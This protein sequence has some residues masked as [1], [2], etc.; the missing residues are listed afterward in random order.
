ML[1]VVFGAV[2]CIYGKMTAGEY[3]AFISYNSLLVWPVRELGRML[4]DMSK[5]GVS[6]ARINYIMSSENEQDKDGAVTPPMN[7]DNT[8]ELR[9]LFRN[10]DKAVFQGTPLSAV[11]LVRQHSALLMRGSLLE[12]VQ[13]LRITA[14]V[15]N[16]DM[17]EAAFDKP[18]DNTFELFIRIER[19]QY[20]SHALQ[21]FKLF[22]HIHSSA[23][24][25]STRL[26]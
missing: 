3:I 22:R 1:V 9:K 25:E 17:L 14:V 21:T 8:F 16:D 7:G 15:D 5:A 24:D 4:S 19:R 11:H 6:I 18:L 13:M 20:D 26:S 2:F 10:V 12:P 23:G